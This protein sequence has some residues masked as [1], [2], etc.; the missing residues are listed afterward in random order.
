VVEVSVPAI[1]KDCPLVLELWRAVTVARRFEGP[2][3]KAE[4]AVGWLWVGL[5][6][7]GGSFLVMVLIDDS[8]V[9]RDDE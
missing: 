4:G 8:E 9:I 5:G 2:S 7:P 1:A 6:Q 3:G